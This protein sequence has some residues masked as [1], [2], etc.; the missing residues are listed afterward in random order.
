MKNYLLQVR[1]LSYMLMRRIHRTQIYNSL[2]NFFLLNK[3]KTVFLFK[4]ITFFSSHTIASTEMHY[5]RLR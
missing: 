5:S 3:T 4:K 2:T 1:I